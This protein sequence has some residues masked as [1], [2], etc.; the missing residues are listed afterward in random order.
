MYILDGLEDFAFAF[1]LQL[2]G[3]RVFESKVLFG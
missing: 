1:D 2:F 3:P